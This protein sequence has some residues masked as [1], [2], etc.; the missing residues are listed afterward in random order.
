MDPGRLG[1]YRLDRSVSQIETCMLAADAPRCWAEPTLLLAMALGGD[2][3]AL[4]TAA[5]AARC[6][7]DRFHLAMTRPGGLLCSIVPRV[8]VVQARPCGCPHTAD[9]FGWTTSLGRRACPR[10]ASPIPQPVQA[11]GRGWWLPSGCRV[12]C[13]YPFYDR[14]CFFFTSAR[15]GG[16]EWVVASAL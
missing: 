10:L 6:R 5:R 8:P 11:P 2:S 13:P 7:H 12:L 9:L 14:G 16:R 1:R 4:I 3:A 15:A